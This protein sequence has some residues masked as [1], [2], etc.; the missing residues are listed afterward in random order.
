MHWQFAGEITLPLFTVLETPTEDCTLLKYFAWMSHPSWR[1]CFQAP[2]RLSSLGFLSSF[3]Q[4]STRTAA[5]ARY[6]CPLTEGMQEA[7]PSRVYCR[8]RVQTVRKVLPVTVP[9]VIGNLS[10]Q[11]SPQ[12][13]PSSNAC[14][15][16]NWRLRRERTI[17]ERS[18]TAATPIEWPPSVARSYRHFH[19]S[20]PG[21]TMS[22]I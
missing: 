22:K 14:V 7:L 12:P 16:N 3:V 18:P 8:T 6:A 11:F 4:A 1:Y 5:D 20:L 13:R 9:D 17:T 21:D 19:L 2:S 15:S 10:C